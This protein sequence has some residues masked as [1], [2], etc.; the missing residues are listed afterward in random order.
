MKI[1]ILLTCVLATTL[2][3]GCN[4]V[5][6]TVDGFGKDVNYVFHSNSQAANQPKTTKVY[7]SHTK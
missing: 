4:T 5:K 3:S 6:G 2:L 1:Q 7:Y